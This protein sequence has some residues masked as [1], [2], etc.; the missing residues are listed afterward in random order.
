MS[1]KRKGFRYVYTKEKA[2]EYKKLSVLQKL[3]WLEKMNRFLYNFMPKESKL[4]AE[5]LRKGEI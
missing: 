1:S 2:A 3:E 4:F 5:R